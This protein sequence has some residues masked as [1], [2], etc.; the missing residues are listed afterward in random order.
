MFHFRVFLKRWCRKKYTNQQIA[1]S[2]RYGLFTEKEGRASFISLSKEINLLT[3]HNNRS[4]SVLKLN[5]CLFTMENSLELQPSPSNIFFQFGPSLYAG[6]YGTIPI[7]KS[8][9]GVITICLH[10]IVSCKKKKSTLVKHK[11]CPPPPCS[12]ILPK[13]TDNI[14]P[15]KVS[16]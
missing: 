14:T 2:L 13:C 12:H 10:A 5:F 15:R 3:V 16:P 1:F 11:H 4:V 7:M 9:Y 6:V 8:W